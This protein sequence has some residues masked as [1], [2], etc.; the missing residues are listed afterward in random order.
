LEESEA[1]SKKDIV[2]RILKILT[3]AFS[4]GYLE[5][6]KE[7][8]LKLKESIKIEA[9]TPH[10]NIFKKKDIDLFIRKIDSLPS[11][12]KIIKN[13]RGDFKNINMSNYKHLIKLRIRI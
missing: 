11:L 6:K 12:I 13:N 2:D 9:D 8:L 5:R 3:E 10:E 7:S 1:F 4:L